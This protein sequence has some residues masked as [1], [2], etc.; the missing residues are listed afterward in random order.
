MKKRIIY[1]FMTLALSATM[2]N[3]SL[4]AETPSS[5]QI[6]DNPNI[7][8][9]REKASKWA[10]S[11]NLKDTKKQNRIENLI[12]THLMAVSDWE[13]AHPYTSV[14]EG[15]NPYTGAKLTKAER[16]V[17]AHSTKPDSI[18]T[19]LMKGLRVELTE[20]QVI[21]IL[22]KYTVGKVAF[23]WKSFS[24]II[25]N[26]T[27][28]E[29]EFILGHLCQAR[30][31]AINYK[32]MDQISAIFKIHKNIIERYLYENDRN[33]RKIYRE[34]VAKINAEKEQKKV[35]NP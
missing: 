13:D 14:A 35:T 24:Q 29:E 9:S 6:Q 2:S 21:H 7:Q 32:T 22:D 3:G 10:E 18:H 1:V 34:F 17:I 19:N 12:F 31:E 20:D 25:P 28:E 4:H 8:K 11:L 15:I 26:I 27:K 30:E 23:T 16:G 5:Q 33:W